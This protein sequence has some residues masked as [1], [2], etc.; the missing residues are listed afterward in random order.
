MVTNGPII[1]RI[2]AIVNRLH[3]EVHKDKIGFFGF[4]ECAN[5][6]DVANALFDTAKNWLRDRGMVCYARAVNPSM[7]D[8]C[9][10]LIE[11][12][13]DSPRGADDLQ[14]PLLS[15]ANERLRFDESKRSVC[16][17]NGGKSCAKLE[18]VANMVEK[19]GRVKI[20]T[21]T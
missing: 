7:N 6:Q 11:G 9:G 8:E 21:T 2:G 13:D 20:R 18:R 14:P 12:F 3:N 15:C 17:E 19:R 4:F 5:R 16:L 1:G 10:L